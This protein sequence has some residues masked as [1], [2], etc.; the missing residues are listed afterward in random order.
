MALTRETH[1]LPLPRQIAGHACPGVGEDMVP[2]YGPRGGAAF[3]YKHQ[4][5]KE[6]SLSGLE[7]VHNRI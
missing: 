2:G 7:P 1:P 5:L 3:P 4:P 6:L